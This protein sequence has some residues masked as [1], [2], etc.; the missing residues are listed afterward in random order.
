MTSPKLKSAK[1]AGLLSETAKTYVE[2][3]W[4]EKEHGYKEVYFTPQ[5]KKGILNERDSLNL[6]QSVL[7]GGYRE[8]NEEKFENDYITGTPDSVPEEGHDGIS[9]Q[10]KDEYSMICFPPDSDFV[11]DVKSSFTVKTFRK[12]GVKPAYYWQGQSYM[13]LKK[14]KYFRLIYCLTPTP[15]HI[16]TELTKPY[17]FK[18]DCDEENPD[19]IEIVNQIRRNHDISHIPM[20]KRIKVFIEEFSTEGIE[21]LI[22]K[23]DM[24]REYYASLSLNDLPSL[25][26][27]GATMNTEGDT[28]VEIR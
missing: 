19:Y 24:A 20:E 21:S 13:W 6:V 27:G 11:E 1:D 22:R 3:I 9:L 18:F 12:A 26:I 10:E 14:R 23:A 28:V 15:E 5:I 4:L 17:Y 2:E 16:I 25:I 7:G 8:K